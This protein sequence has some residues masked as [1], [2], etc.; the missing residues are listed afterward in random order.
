MKKDI[1]EKMACDISECVSREMT[2]EEEAALFEKEAKEIF[3]KEKKDCESSFEVCVI[4]RGMR[5]IRKAREERRQMDASVEKVISE[6][7]CKITFLEKELEK[8]SIVKAF[9]DKI[10]G[11]G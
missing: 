9:A 7:Q 11:K 5:I 4:R 10:L 3:D 8:H 1:G 2:F 6:M